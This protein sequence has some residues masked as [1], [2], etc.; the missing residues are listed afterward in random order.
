MDDYTWPNLLADTDY[1]IY[2]IAID[3]NGNFG[4][5]AEGKFHTTETPGEDTAEYRQF[6]GTW[7]MDYTDAITQK[8]GTMQVEIT[9]RVV[10]KSYY[11]SGLITP[12]YIAQWGIVNSA[13]EGRFEDGQLRL[14]VGRPMID[15]GITLT[16]QG[17]S[18]SFWGYN[19]SSV[20]VPGEAALAGVCSG[21]KVEFGDYGGYGLKGYVWVKIQNGLSAEMADSVIPTKI[22]LTRISNSTSSRPRTTGKTLQPGFVE[23][24]APVEVSV[25]SWLKPIRLVSSASVEQA[26][27]MTRLR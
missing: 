17:Y 21:D 2:C 7:Q 23:R 4:P 9:E 25:S 27:P 1:T 26:E 8:A 13:M 19:G 10:G 14:Y 3:E 15:V 5:L 20:Y 6:I 24:I 18:L 11:V 16:N 22:T 12:E